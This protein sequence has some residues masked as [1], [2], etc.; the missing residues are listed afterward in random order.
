MTQSTPLPDKINQAVALTDLQVQQR[1][2]IKEVVELRQQERA[3]QQGMRVDPEQTSGLHVAEGA[4]RLVQLRK[5]RNAAPV[6]G[7]A[8]QRRRDM[9]GRSLEKPNAEVV[10]QLL[11]CFCG[12]RPGKAEV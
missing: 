4:F 11:D 7:R 1:V 6:E 12:G 10:F 5:D 2:A 9:P 3:C 8:V